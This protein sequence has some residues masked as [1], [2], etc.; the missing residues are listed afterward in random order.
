[1]VSP[2]DIALII[3]KFNPID[4]DLEKLDAYL[5]EHKINFK[6]FL[7][8]KNTKGFYTM[9]FPENFKYMDH[10]NFQDEKCFT[11]RRDAKDFEYLNILNKKVNNNE[12]YNMN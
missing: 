1:M 8:L 6:L 3:K 12:L 7:P 9:H 2:Y 4:F 11:E 5:L 10:Y